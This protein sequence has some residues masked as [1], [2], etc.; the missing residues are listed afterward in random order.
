MF[1]G[2]R[3]LVFPV[4]VKISRRLT[5]THTYIYLC[6]QT[7]GWD[8]GPV[9][10][11]EA[12]GLET[13]DGEEEEDD[14]DSTGGFSCGAKT[15]ARDTRRVWAEERAKFETALRARRERE[16][17]VRLR[18]RHG[19]SFLQHLSPVLSLGRGA[20][21][22]GGRIAAEEVE[23]E[24]AAT[25]AA[26]TDPLS[27]RRQQQQQTTTPLLAEVHRALAALTGGALA[28]APEPDEE[29]LEEAEE[30]AAEL[31]ALAASWSASVASAGGE[32]GSAAAGA[33]SSSVK[34]QQLPQQSTATALVITTAT[35][36]PAALRR[37][38]PLLLLG[39]GLPWLFHHHHRPTPH[40][41]H[42]CLALLATAILRQLGVA[43]ASPRSRAL[44]RGA[45]LLSFVFL[46]AAMASLLWSAFCK[47]VCVFGCGVWIVDG[48]NLNRSGREAPNP[49]LH[50]S[51]ITNTQSHTHRPV[52]LPNRSRPVGRLLRQKPSPPP[53]SSHD[54]A[55]ARLQRVETL[56]L[57][58]L[59]WLYG[60]ARRAWR[61]YLRSR[62]RLWEE[63]G[64]A[65]PPDW[66]REGNN[67]KVH[68]E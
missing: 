5:L 45:F 28:P 49:I 3:C 15:P 24:D 37:L 20:S 63:W 51:T 54:D 33:A 62:R 52:L 60:E 8:L 59:L 9:P 57:P 11:F 29:E 61:R 44:R 31:V 67:N 41:A 4:E 32:G 14:K 66:E 30:D 25:D 40:I 68:V 42:L 53:I 43:L 13:E 55:W 7:Q 22:G 64:Y 48:W 18:Q 21:G 38:L 6:T 1:L 27:R 19:G 12:E 34:P 23:E 56:Y 39:G 58:L 36:L 10:V 65:C 35:A 2:V 16:A 47:Y 50:S 17:R 46:L 26:A